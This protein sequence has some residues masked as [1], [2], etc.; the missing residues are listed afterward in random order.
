MKN[1]VSV[2]I[3]TRNRENDLK[4]CLGSL[5]CQLKTLDELIVIDNNSSDNTKLVITNFSKAVSFNVKYIKHIKVGYPHVYNRGLK[6]AK[7]DWVAFIDDD[8][9]ADPDW[10]LRIKFITSNLRK[11][12]VILGSSKEYYL[13]S[14]MALTKSYIDEVGKLGV[15]RKRLI[16]DHEVL[17]SKNI[18]YNKKFLEKNK[19]KF[20]S[21]LLKYAQGASEDCDLGMQIFQAKGIAIYDDKIKVSHKDLTSFSS[22]Y[23]KTYHTLKNHLVYE[24]KWEIVRTNIFTK[25]LLIEKIKLFNEFNKRYNLSKIRKLI[26]LVNVVSTFIYI[27]VFRLLLK[28]EINS[29]N[30]KQK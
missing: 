18:I 7:G 15:I 9:V 4:H 6:E 16:L 3:T 27:K 20:D 5:S 17:D 25:R 23:K 10:Y 19:I 26:L 1:K 28:P 21:S 24:K 14:I 8:C 2:V 13:Q 12:N 11:V 30:I 22:Y 29:M